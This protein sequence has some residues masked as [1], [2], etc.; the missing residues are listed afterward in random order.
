MLETDRPARE[1]RG[2]VLPE[3]LT[4]ACLDELAS[5]LNMHSHEDNEE[6]NAEAAVRAFR[7][8]ERHLR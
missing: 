5:L 4:P 3:G 2:V 7:V 6:T 8:V 1:H